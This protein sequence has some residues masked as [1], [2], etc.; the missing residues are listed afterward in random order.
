MTGFLRR[1][2]LS[3]LQ[4]I[5]LLREVDFFSRFLDA[6]R[7]PGE[8]DLLKGSIDVLCE[9]DGRFYLLDLKSN[10]LPDYEPATLHHA[11]MAHYLLQAQVYLLACLAFLGIRD[12]AAYEARFGGILYVFL[13]GLPEKGTWSLRPTWAEVQDWKHDLARVHREVIL[14]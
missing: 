2:C 6:D 10:L 1:Y 3:W 13:R 5:R 14:G 9:S 4:S 8:K 7:Y 12:E 11:V